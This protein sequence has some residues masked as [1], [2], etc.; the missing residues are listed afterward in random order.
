MDLEAGALA[1]G[2]M[3]GKVVPLVVT[4][5]ANPSVRPA[6]VMLMAA[7][8]TPITTVRSGTTGLRDKNHLNCGAR[9]TMVE[10][11]GNHKD[12][13][14]PHLEEGHIRPQCPM[15]VEKRT[16]RMNSTTSRLPQVATGSM[17]SPMA[18][19]G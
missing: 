13:W 11:S 1:D 3:V 19:T 16:L 18:M 7:A 5:A 10:H 12:E 4:T 15:L 9:I 6:T 2:R 17:D 8:D 14:F